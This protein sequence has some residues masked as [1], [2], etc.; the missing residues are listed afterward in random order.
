MTRTLNGLLS[1]A[2]LA[3]AL[4]SLPA[5]EAE[6][7]DNDGVVEIAAEPPPPQVE[8]IPAVPYAGAVWIGGAWEWRGGR[9]VWVGGR[10]VRPR[11]GYVYQAHRW[12]RTPAGRWRHSP[13]GWRRR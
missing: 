3:A 10:Y 2:A 8:V 6:V 13:G 5:C 12:E 9:H 7:Y 4:A 11:A 1:G